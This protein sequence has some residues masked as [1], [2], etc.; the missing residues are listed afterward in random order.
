[1]LLPPTGIAVSEVVAT[2]ND[3]AKEVFKPLLKILFD[4]S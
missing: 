3:V 1:M 2:Y 4:Y